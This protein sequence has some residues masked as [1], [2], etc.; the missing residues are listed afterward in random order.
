MGLDAGAMRGD[1]SV[2]TDGGVIVDGSAVTDGGAGSGDAL[3]TEQVRVLIEKPAAQD[4]VLATM[5]LEPEAR[6]DVVTGNGSVDSLAEL[7]GW[8]V[9]EGEPD[10]KLSARTFMPAAASGRG[11]GGAS[12]YLLKGAP[13]DV[14]G[15]PSGRYTLVVQ[16]T[17]VS[18]AVGTGTAAFEL[19]AGPTLVILTPSEG[20]SV[21]NSVE[22]RFSASD[23]LFAPLSDVTLMLGRYAV[24]VEPTETP[25]VYRAAVNFNAYDPPLDGEQLISVRAKNHNGTETVASR[26]FVIDND[27]PVIANTLPV[28]G[29]LIGQIVELRAEI[30]DA[31]GV[32]KNSVVA[33]IGNGDKLLTV[34]LDPPAAG[35]T[36]PIYKAR[37][38]T[39][40]LPQNAFF[41][42]LSFRAQDILGN[43][44]SIGYVLS[45]D[46]TPPLADLDPPS[47]FRTRIKTTTWTCTWPF[48]PVGPD[49]VDDGDT[50]TQLFDVRARIEDQGNDQLSGPA[51]FVPIATVDE[52]QANLL[53]LDDT[54]QPLVVDTNNDGVCDALNPQLV[55][56][57]TPMTSRDALLINLVPI[58][59]TGS[60]DQSADPALLGPAPPGWGAWPCAPGVVAPPTDPICRTT[61]D[62]SKARWDNGYPHAVASD[63][64]ISYATAGL[65]AIWTVPPI[66]QDM[67][68]CQGRQFDA[69]ANNV[70][71]GWACL[72]VYAV[73]KLGNAQVSR[74]I[75]A[76]VDKDGVGG[77][78]PHV[79]ITGVSNSTP[80]VV[81]TAAAHGY[82][83][84][85]VVI[86][87][88][89]F[90]Q[91]AA[92]G[93][94]PV[95][96]LTPTSFE[97][98]GS[99]GNPQMPADD[100]QRHIDPYDPG[101]KA[102][103]RLPYVVLERQLPDC[104]GTQPSKASN[105]V[106]GTA[107]KP[108][109][110]YPK[111]EFSRF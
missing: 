75:R 44:S 45:M 77:E 91:T 32:D 100:G 56:T 73:D 107:C 88:G 35:D 108:W 36:M 34:K 79:R 12:T 9:R 42:S 38:D 78:C 111:Y 98:Q 13:L 74:V 57:T 52:R 53:V 30:T 90:N 110:A 1:G 71:D 63:Q 65:P 25:D 66:E 15:L 26:K 41:P 81:T 60:G 62:L 54:S 82:A 28:K 2:V 67:L 16:A 46:N 47:N 97:L 83:T 92:N 59:P 22:I 48:D 105:E 101:L 8:L 3:P 70:R 80:V 10:K 23:A 99:I 50:V 31:A 61:A 94:W 72:A 20:Q 55:P 39:R 106:N 37:F 95:R 18:G 6:I 86:V 27:G 89:V 64:V 19:D 84:G 43:E 102:T 17:T 29:S 33:V 85:D 51:D 103:E 96:V 14:A 93:H 104:T 58:T 68:Q 24:T 87:S 40:L 21:R 7:A 5:G 11:D 109:R 49:A 4:R 76:C 69:L